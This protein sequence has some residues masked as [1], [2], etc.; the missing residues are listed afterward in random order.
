MGST[1]QLSTRQHL[2]PSTVR[3][4][5]YATRGTHITRTHRVQQLEARGT[6]H[7]YD[8]SQRQVLRRC[9]R[10]VSKIKANVRRVFAP[11]G[12]RPQRVNMKCPRSSVTLPHQPLAG[13]THLDTLHWSKRLAPFAD[14]LLS[15]SWREW[16]WSRHMWRLCRQR[17]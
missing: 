16:L 14:W 12:R 1:V 13:N 5:M 17:N 7:V 9:I 8:V 11:S 15:R 4:D 6:M 3:G 10:T 2:D